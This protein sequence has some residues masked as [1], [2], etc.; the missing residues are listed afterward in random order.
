MAF[1]FKFEFVVNSDNFSPNSLTNFVL[2]PRLTLLSISWGINKG[3]AWFD[4][5]PM[6]DEDVC[7]F[8]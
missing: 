1:I 2:Y 3:F 8:G 5:G 4:L 7:L 6:F